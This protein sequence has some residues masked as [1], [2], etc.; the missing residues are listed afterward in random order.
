MQTEKHEEILNKVI[1][2][3]S[4]GAEIPYELQVYLEQYELQYILDYT[5]EETDGH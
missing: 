4:Q 5:K 1:K 2:L 3:I